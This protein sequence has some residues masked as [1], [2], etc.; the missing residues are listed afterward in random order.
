MNGVKVSLSPT[1]IDGGREECEVFVGL[2]GAFTFVVVV[3]KV[4]IFV[5]GRTINV[6]VRSLYDSSLHSEKSARQLSSDYCAYDM[7]GVMPLF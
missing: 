4:R 2:I 3:S 6:K 5:A 7:D 1:T